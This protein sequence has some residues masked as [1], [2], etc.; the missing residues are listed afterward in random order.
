MNSTK[1]KIFLLISIVIISLTIFHIPSEWI[2]D[3]TNSYCI[4][5]SIFGIEC[6]F[7]GMTRA[8]YDMLH[9]NFTDVIHENFVV[10]PFVVTFFFWI[11]AFIFKNAILRKTA[12]IMTYISAA[13]FIII[14]TLRITG[15]Y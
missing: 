3:N 1:Q 2:H 8:V 9:F 15:L 14:Y 7:C 13:G 4:H 6:P 11:S 5:K 12:Q 10:I